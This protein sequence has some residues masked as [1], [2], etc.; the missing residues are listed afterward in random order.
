MNKCRDQKV[1]HGRI[2]HLEGSLNGARANVSCNG[3]FHING[4][5][6]CVKTETVQCT[7]SNYGSEWRSNND[8]LIPSCERMG[9]TNFKQN[10]QITC[11]L[12]RMNCA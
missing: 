5:S 12:L 1:F 7:K 6:T 11:K 2:L 3:G 4:Q 8:S 10:R 9:R